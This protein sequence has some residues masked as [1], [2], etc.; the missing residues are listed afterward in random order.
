MGDVIWCDCQLVN[1]CMTNGSAA[2]PTRGLPEVR[3][4]G[5]GRQAAPRFLTFGEFGS[6]AASAGWA[7]QLGDR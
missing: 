3:P 1:P 2:V 7:G 5:R 4:G 6:R